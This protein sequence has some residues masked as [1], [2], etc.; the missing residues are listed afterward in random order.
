[1]GNL[2]T[3]R[4]SAEK[5]FRVWPREEVRDLVRFSTLLALGIM[6]NTLESLILP[7]G[8]PVRLGLANLSM[9]CGLF[10]LRPRDLFLLAAF[11]VIISSLIFG[12]FFQLPMWLGLAGGL[13]AAVVM[14]AAFAAGR[15]VFSWVGVSLLGA[16]AHATAQLGLFAWWFAPSVW[17]LYPWFLTLS[18]L[19]GLL[20]GGLMLGI[21]RRLTGDR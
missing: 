16:A 6:L 14:E 13:S 8:W 5:G 19:G 17:S 18:L 4:S 12:Y 11:R 9:M 7:R 20:M 2:A 10:F 1:M 21:E 3:I 15:G